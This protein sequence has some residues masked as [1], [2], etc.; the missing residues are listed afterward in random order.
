MRVPGLRAWSAPT[1]PCSR[2][3]LLAVA[4]GGLR[5]TAQDVIPKE[6]T[7]FLDLVVEDA[8]GRPVRNLT[9]EDVIIRQQGVRQ[10]VA[11]L[12]AREPPGHYELSYVPASGQAGAVVVQLLRP[13]TRAHGPD[14]PA[15][16]PRVVQPLSPLEATLTQVLETRADA[17]D[18]P[19]HASVLRFDAAKDGIHHTLALEVPLGGLIAPNTDRPSALRLQIFARLKEQGT[20]RVVRRFELDRSLSAN[21]PATSLQ[22]MVWTGQVHLGSGRYL[23]EAV[24]YDPATARA[25]V[26]RVSFDATDPEPGLRL[27]SVALLQPLGTMVVREQGREADDPFILGQEPVMPTLELRT[28]A[29]PGAK[30]EFFAIVYPEGA[31]PNPVTLTL[32]VLRDGNV[33]DSAP[34]PLPAPDAHGEIRYAGGIPT[35]NLD[36]AE[37]RLRLHAQQGAMGRFEEVPF[38]VLAQSGAA[39]IRVGGLPSSGSGVKPPASARPEPPELAAARR[40]ILRHQYDEALRGLQKADGLANG[41]NGDVVLVLG[42]TYY[43]LEAYKDAET[44]VRRAIDLAKDDAGLLG[45]A[46]ILLGRVM[47]SAEKRP[48]RKDSERLRAA[49]DAFRKVLAMP[50]IPPESSRLP[51]A[52]TLFRLDRAGEARE[53]LKT[54]LQEP[55]LTDAGGDRARQLLR[56]PRCATERCLPRLSFVTSDGRHQTTEDLRGKVVLLSFWAA[57]CEPCVAALPDL[58]RIFS[59]NEKGPFV[60][61]GVDMHDERA[62]MDSFIEKHGLRWP[63]ISGEASERIIDAMAVRSIPTEVLFDHEGVLVSGSTGWGSASGSALFRDIAQAVHKAKRQ[64]GATSVPVP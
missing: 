30:V 31:N 53:I 4:L 64:A 26:R 9:P 38:T 55:G 52:E 48:V 34:L 54:L 1:L 16:K 44:A 41:K 19:A 27:S 39:P 47:A 29:A 2:A 5:A 6:L 13:G 33:V 36:P 23:M 14:G 59:V 3:L 20:G 42:I 17:D 11:R 60:M 15:L 37:Y 24:A 28:L 32:E 63:Q 58:Q 57:W 56:S 51:L 21:A 50:E 22:R 45:Q 35:R 62:A 61:I 7:V 40:L 49:E 25:S 10:R 43:R 18:F 12:E 8:N 46:Y